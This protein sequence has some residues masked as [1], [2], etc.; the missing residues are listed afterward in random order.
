MVYC[1]VLGKSHFIHY[2]LFIQCIFN[3]CVII[4]LHYSN[5]SIILYCLNLHLNKDPYWITYVSFILSRMSYAYLCEI[6]YSLNTT[7]TCRLVVRVTFKFSGQNR[8]VSSATKS[9][10]ESKNC[11]VIEE[12]SSARFRSILFLGKFNF[13][14]KNFNS[15]RRKRH[16]CKLKWVGLIL[17]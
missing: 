3:I 4:I 8:F 9:K 15:Q 14:S 12:T 7:E 10:E 11:Q 16:F 13:R 2:L 1:V 5:L 6:R 17:G